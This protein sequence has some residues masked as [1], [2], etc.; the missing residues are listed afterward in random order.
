MTW[1]S[2]SRSAKLLENI[3]AMADRGG[4]FSG[5][6]PLLSKPSSTRWMYIYIHYI[7]PGLVNVGHRIRIRKG[8]EASIQGVPCSTTLLPRQVTC[9]HLLYN[10]IKISESST[11]LIEKSTDH[12]IYHFTTRRLNIKI[13]GFVHVCTRLFSAF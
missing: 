11:R 7:H 6:R 2:R 12:R 3:L 8:A 10:R 9:H 1:S 4:A 5:T 13:F